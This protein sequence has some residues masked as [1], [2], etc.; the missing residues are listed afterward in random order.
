MAPT[1]SDAKATAPPAAPTFASDIRARAGAVAGGASRDRPWRGAR[2]SSPRP[3][4]ASQEVGRLYGSG[5]GKEK[6]SGLTT[7]D[8]GGRSDQARGVR[9]RPT[10]I[11]NRRS[12]GK[13]HRAATPVSDGFR[14]RRPNGLTQGEA[15]PPPT[16]F[17]TG[18][19]LPSTGAPAGLPPLP[20]GWEALPVQPAWTLPGD[21]PSEPGDPRRIEKPRKR[22][23]G[24][25]AIRAY[26]DPDHVG[27]IIEFPRLPRKERRPG[28]WERQRVPIRI[29]PRRT[30]PPANPRPRRKPVPKLR[31]TMR[32]TKTRTTCRHHCGHPTTGRGVASGRCAHPGRGR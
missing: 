2:H 4:R 3:R 31:R 22:Y 20:R 15:A 32:P 13:S 8:T 21:G 10:R 17:R 28:S 23:R 14:D 18:G 12:T 6:T 16:E 24:L 7:P 30:D 27:E 11:P 5:R 29:G 1:L 19:P 9:D 26:I 25:S